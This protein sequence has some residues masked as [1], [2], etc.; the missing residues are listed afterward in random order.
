MTT[1]QI[2]FARLQ[3]EARSNRAQEA[4]KG[5]SISE[6]QRHNLAG[7]RTNW[8]SAE[9]A[10]SIGGL[11]AAAAASQAAAAHR[12][13][14]VGEMNASTQKGRLDLDIAKYYGSGQGLE[15]AK[16]GEI[17]ESTRGKRYQNDTNDYLSPQW[18][19]WW[20]TTNE[21]MDY[22]TKPFKVIVGR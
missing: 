7:E 15:L 11:Q 16:T 20:N 1:N 21:A 6:E 4:L 22:F 18:R 17:Q 10:R 5:Q 8:F 3:E 9:T 12:N 13:A 2:N 19:G 14:S